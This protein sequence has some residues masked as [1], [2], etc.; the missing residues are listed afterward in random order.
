MEV[1]W[2]RLM[3]TPRQQLHDLAREFDERH[4]LWERTIA[5]AELAQELHHGAMLRAGE[6][7]HRAEMSAIGAHDAAGYLKRIDAD[8]PARADAFSLHA[9]LKVLEKNVADPL[10]GLTCDSRISR[11]R[12]G[13]WE[14][15]ANFMKQGRWKRA[16]HALN[17]LQGGHLRRFADRLRFGYTEDD[18]AETAKETD[19]AK[20]AI[21]PYRENCKR[22]A[23]VRTDLGAAE[24]AMAEHLY[25][26][27]EKDSVRAVLRDPDVK[28]DVRSSPALSF[29]ARHAGDG[30]DSMMDSIRNDLSAQRGKI[31]L[32]DMGE[33]FHVLT[34]A[35]PQLVE[36]RRQE[37]LLACQRYEAAKQF[38]GSARVAQR[39]ET[40]TSLLADGMYEDIRS[41]LKTAAHMKDPDISAL[42]ESARIKKSRWVNAGRLQRTVD[43]IERPDFDPADA[44]FMPWRNYTINA[45]LDSL[46]R[47]AWDLPL[48]PVKASAA[49]VAG[50][51][52]GAWESV[53]GEEKPPAPGAGTGTRPNFRKSRTP[54]EGG[55]PPPAPPGGPK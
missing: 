32:R 40:K 43:V 7:R 38:V 1:P 30:K 44:R 35:A 31:S 25:A 50:L 46:K 29:L 53:K 28:N 47:S 13:V 2:R 41:E 6:N 10:R 27:L 19:A 23:A 36:R 24:N 37:N 3:M 12:A 55:P 16:E 8:D 45:G 5:R 15:Y 14:E 11:M 51:F 20:A 18:Q 39:L 48:K 54:D 22:L 17:K 49:F 52:K 33:S 4:N 26:L 42:V 21:D 34:Q 9:T